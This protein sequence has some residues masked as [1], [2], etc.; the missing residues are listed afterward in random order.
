MIEKREHKYRASNSVEIIYKYKPRKYDFNHLLIVFSG[1]LHKY[2]GNYDFNNAL[3]DCPADVIWINDNFEEMYTYY[4][5]INMD[6][7]VEEAVTEFINYKIKEFGLD[8]QNVT[9]TGFSKGGSAA[10]YYGLKLPVANIVTTVPQIKI[11]TYLVN[12][13]EHVARHMMGELTKAK[14]DYL[15]KIII[16]LL[17]KE[18]YFNKN[19]YLLTSEADIQ[20]EPEI[21]PILEDLRKYSNFNLIKT[22]SVFCRE[23]NQI[24]SHHTAILLGLY[25]CLASE[26]TPIFQHNEVNFFGSQPLPPI[27][28]K[29]IP[30]I[31]TRVINI[32][33]QRLFIE[34]VAILQGYDLIEYKDIDYQLIFKGKNTIIKPMAK[35]HRPYLTKEFFDGKNLVIYDK[36]W[37]TTPQNQGIDISDI[38]TDKYEL[39]IKISTHSISKRL[40]LVT[41][42]NFNR[43]SEKYHISSENSKIILELKK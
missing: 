14:Q 28:K 2:P 42:K 20:Y 33:E 38:P 7:K 27:E 37:F 1:F 24:T 32:K 35:A 12:T 3:D 39:F 17:K 8:Y 22:Y 34:G 16:K 13:W 6:F 31:D 15:D 10:L 36:G 11:G 18:R 26:A 5:C 25:Y 21:K 29:G 30:V 40:P 41:N 19:I 9:I 4:L 23:H 43:E